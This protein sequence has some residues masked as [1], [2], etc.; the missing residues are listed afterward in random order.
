MVTA[1]VSELHS[2]FWIEGIQKTYTCLR[3]VNGGRKKLEVHVASCNEEIKITQPAA[4]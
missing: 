2:E 1:E 4:W 3:V